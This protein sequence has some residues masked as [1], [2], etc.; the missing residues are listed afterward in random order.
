MLPL[1]HMPVKRAFL[2][3]NDIQ[4]IIRIGKGCSTYLGE[5]VN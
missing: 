1:M 3:L 5:S 4:S 2:T